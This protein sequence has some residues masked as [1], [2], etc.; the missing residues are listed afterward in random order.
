[1]IRE[2]MTIWA[3]VLVGAAIG[4]GLTALYLVAR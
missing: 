3:S 2:F 4:M 1:M